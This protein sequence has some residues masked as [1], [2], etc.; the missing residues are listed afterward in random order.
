MAE[1]VLFCAHR[2]ALLPRRMR[3]SP[4]IGRE[5]TGARL[6]S[7]AAAIACTSIMGMTTGLAW[8]LLALRLEHRGFDAAAIGVNAAAQSMGI[9]AV[10]FIAPW[11]IARIGFVRG[12]GAAISGA[13]A[14]MLLLPVFDGYGAWLL[15]RFLLGASSCFLFI[16]GE[17]WI[18]LIAPSRYLG[19]VVG[20]LGLVWGGTF[21][22]GPI[23]VGIVGIDGWTPFLVGAAAAFCAGLPLF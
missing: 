15:L 20:I 6:F 1:A 18:V 21:A 4:D 14:M 5:L 19:R 8:T 11:A 9:F 7:L 10:G 2:A 22:L 13:I 12:C 17:S 3:D 23:I 16:A